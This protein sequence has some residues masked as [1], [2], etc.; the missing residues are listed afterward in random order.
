MLY[1]K[2]GE[3]IWNVDCPQPILGAVLLTETSIGTIRKSCAGIGAGF[4]EA[5]MESDCRW[6]DRRS[7]AADHET[8]YF[9]SGD[10]YIYAV[11]LH[12]G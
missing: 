3:L 4:W 11:H 8:I 1:G 9:G 2:T 10:G 5:Y 12:T 7:P 6:F